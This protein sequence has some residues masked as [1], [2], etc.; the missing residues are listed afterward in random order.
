MGKDKSVMEKENNKHMNAEPEDEASE[1]LYSAWQGDDVTVRDDLHDFSILLDAVKVARRKGSR[2]RLIDTGK[3]DS[4]QLEWIAKAGAD[5]YTSSE[6]RADFIEL[7]L[8]NKACK[9]GSATC[10]Y[11]HHGPFDTEEESGSF[12]YSGLQDLGRSGIYLH[13]T[14]RQEKRDGIR[15]EELAFACRRGGSWLV[16]YHHGLLEFSLDELARNGAWIH[17]TEQIL[18]DA[19]DQA[20]V[21]DKVRSAVSAGLR[22][23]LHVEK[24]LDVS[25]LQDVMSSG[26]F[27]LFAASLFKDKSPLNVLARKARQK[28]RNFRAYY[29]YPNIMP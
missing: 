25:L 13:L 11:F 7:E 22:F 29:L 27:I 28:K 1:L 6:A 12:S 15:L 3:L 18:R 5:V 23:V 21:L 10:A 16:Y 19:E 26:A 24:G 14:N 20:L 17:A 4:S 2:F 8:V 9:T